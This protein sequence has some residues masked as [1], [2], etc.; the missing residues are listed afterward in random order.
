MKKIFSIVAIALSACAFSQVI[1]GDAIGTASNKQ[2]VL[3]D[4][5]AGQNKGIIIPYVRTVPSG[6][7][8]AEGTII[9]DAS[10]Q[11]KAKVKFYNGVISADSPEGWADLSNG[12]GADINAIMTAQPMLAEDAG[13]KVIIGSN[14][15]TADGV[16][17]LESDAKAM[18]LPM[19]QDTN[20]ILNPA[21]GMMVYINKTG[22]KRLAVYNG[23][24]WTYWK[25]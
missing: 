10:D 24:G 1:F 25:P 4:F 8:L 2:S 9:L 12:H 7:G 5:A 22:A 18:I 15:S 11:T 20:D 13:A 17:V 21:P 6:A 16:L 3:V 19:V 14:S 23:E